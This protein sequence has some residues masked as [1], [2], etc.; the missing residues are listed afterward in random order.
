MDSHSLSLQWAVWW[1][2]SAWIRIASSVV[3]IITF[4]LSLNPYVFFVLFIFFEL[5]RHFKRDLSYDSMLV[6][7]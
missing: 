1:Q 3:T 7:T 5:L 2:I 6:Q 4:F